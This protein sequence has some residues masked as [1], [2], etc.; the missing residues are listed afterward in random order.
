MIVGGSVASAQ[1]GYYPSSGSTDIVSTFDNTGTFSTVATYNPPPVIVRFDYGSPTPTAQHHISWSN[2]SVA[3]GYDNTPSTGGP[4]HQG[5]A[6]DTGGSLQLSQTFSTSDGYGQSAFIFDI[7]PTPG[8]GVTA[9]SFDILVNPLTTLPADANHGFGYFQFVQRLTDSY[10]YTEVDQSVYV[11]GNL[12]GTSGSS[13]YSGPGMNLGNPS[14]GPNS[15]TG[16]WDHVE[17]DYSSPQADLRALSLQDYINGP[18]RN[19]VL[20][21]NID[22]LEVTTVPVPE[23]A[24]LG[25]LALSV[26]ALLARR[27]FAKR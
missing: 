20:V 9:V 12:I 4:A 15:D 3:G 17:I 27:R 1:S 5:T 6:L 8:V 14:Y 10:V 26:P 18:G 13:P 7:Y 21:Y 24:S 19:G 2:G 22:N 25:L 11:N 16:T 23:P